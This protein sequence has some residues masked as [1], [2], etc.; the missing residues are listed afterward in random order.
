VRRN[1]AHHGDEGGHFARR[2][3]FCLFTA[4]QLAAGEL[5][6]VARSD[7]FNFVRQSLSVSHL[8]RRFHRVS[9][10]TRIVRSVRDQDTWR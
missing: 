4:L 6:R 8:F 7:A 9:V 2:E 3:A 5:R 10:N 1:A